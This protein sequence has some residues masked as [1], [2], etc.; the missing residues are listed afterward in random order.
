MHNGLKPEQSQPGRMVQYRGY[1]WFLVHRDIARALPISY[2]REILKNS[3]AQD[4][5]SRWRCSIDLHVG[6]EI[7]FSFLF[8]RDELKIEASIH[9][10]LS[11]FD[12]SEKTNT[13]VIFIYDTGA[14][15]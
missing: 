10:P 13:F 6:H 8:I 1:G 4:C 15:G 9:I 12:N 5:K 3:M 11:V 7:F 14:G 2:Y